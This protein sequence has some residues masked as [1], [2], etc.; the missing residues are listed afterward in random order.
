MLLPLS[1]SPTQNPVHHS[2]P[3]CE[4]SLRRGQGSTDCPRSDRG[5]PWPRSAPWIPNTTKLHSFFL[6][7]SFHIVTEFPLDISS[8]NRSNNLSILPDLES[9]RISIHS[10]IISSDIL[11][12]FSVLQ[13]ILSLTVY[14]LKVLFFLRY[15][16]VLV[17]GLSITRI[18][19]HV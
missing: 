9:N 19:Q 16:A 8:Q 1:K 10:L 18:H 5:S 3:W 4:E 6:C 7:R 13:Q 11:S 17:S 2:T 14:H 12:R 15:C